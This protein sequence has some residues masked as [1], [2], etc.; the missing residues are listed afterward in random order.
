MIYNHLKVNNFVITVVNL[1]FETQILLRVNEPL[2]EKVTTKATSPDSCRL[3]LPRLRGES[4]RPPNTQPGSRYLLATTAPHRQI[5]HHSPYCAASQSLNLCGNV[6][7]N[8]YVPC[9]K[10]RHQSVDSW[11]AEEAKLPQSGERRQTFA[12]RFPSI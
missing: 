2:Q 12:H 11:F 10:M 5:C 1:S 6:H 3:S 9:L 8:T 7:A 4:T